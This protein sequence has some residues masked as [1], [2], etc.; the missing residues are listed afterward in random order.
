M[1]AVKNDTIYPVILSV[2]IQDRQ[3]KGKDKAICLSRLARQALEISAQESGVFL[4]NLLKDSSGAPLPFKGFYWS[5]THKSTYVGAVIAT[6][7]IGIDIEKIRSINKSIFI[8]TA[9]EKEWQLADEDPVLL[10]FRYWTSKEAVLK[11]AATGLKDLTRCRIVRVLDRFNLVINYL[12]KSWEVEHF[13]F[14]D[15]IATIVKT[16]HN[17]RWTLL[18]DNKTL[19]G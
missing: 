6:S 4:K 17:I 16:A 9:D 10:F 11:A 19:R 3:L 18:E 13:F 1:K 8:K 5:L 12:D 14:K 2:P 15:H 7:R